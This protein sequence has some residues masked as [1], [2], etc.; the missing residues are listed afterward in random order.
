MKRRL[1]LFAVCT[2]VIAPLLAFGVNEE[3]ASAGHETTP[4]A[5]ASDPGGGEHG[6]G[7][8]APAQSGPAALPNLISILN[9]ALNPHHE[10]KF[11][12]F[13]HYA[14]LP[15]FSGAIGICLILF[16]RKVSL[17]L[18]TV[19]GRMQCFAEMLIGGLYD[20]FTEVLGSRKAG[21][22]H[23]PFLGTLFIYIWCNNMLGLVPL[24]HSPTGGVAPSALNTT[25]ALAIIVFFYVQI[26]SISELGI[27]GY[28]DH[29]LGSPR[30]LIGWLL[31]PLMAPLHILEEFIK[32]MSLALRLF[33]NITGEDALIAAFAVVG[34]SAFSLVFGVG[35]IGIP[36]QV[37]FMFLAL[38]CG[39]IQALVF[40]LLSAIYIS[41]MSHHEEHGEE[42]GAEAH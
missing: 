19:P 8:A 11:L 4:A 17:N 30:D 13:L 27:F 28:F 16:F 22:K 40:T 21:R 2:I 25:A 18:K 32:P 23:I 36:L 3:H 1:A 14:E 20:F 5:H 29:L 39:T 34:I 10:N 6:G 37:P 38:L 33:G 24:G 41:L 42:H 15:I 7:H 35:L 12:N 26:N 31:V 9:H